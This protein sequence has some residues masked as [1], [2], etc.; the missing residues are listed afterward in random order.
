[1]TFVVTPDQ[2]KP[3]ST[4]SASRSA[5][6]DER[7][8]VVARRRRSRR[9]SST[10]TTRR[11][12][13][14]T[15]L[16]DMIRGKVQADLSGPIGITKQIAKAAEPRRG[17]TSCR[18]IIDAVGLPGPLQPAAAAGARR[19]AR[20][21]P[22]RR[23]GH[24]PEASTRASRRPCTRRVSCCCSACCW[25][26]ASR[27]SSGRASVRGATRRRGERGAGSAIHD[28]LVGA[29]ALVGTPYLA[30]PELR[31]EYARDIAPRTRGGAGEDPGRGLSP[32]AR[33]AP[34]AR[35]RSGRRDGRGGRGAARALRRRRS[36][37]S[38]VD[39]VAGARRRHGGSRRRRCRA[40]DGRFDLI[41][42][43]HLLGELFV[44][45]PLDERVDARARRVRAW[46]EAL[47]APGGTVDPGRAGAA[48]DLA[49]AAGRARP[50]A[51]AADL[52]RS[53]RPASGRA[54]ARRSPA[55]ATGATT[56]RRRRRRRAAR[57]LQLPGAAR[58]L[59]ADPGPAALP[60]RQRSAAREGPA[61]ALRLRPDR[62]AR[63]SSAST[64]TNRR[65][66]PRSAK[67]VRGDVARIAGE[68]EANDGM[69]V[70]ATTAVAKRSPRSYVGAGRRQ[71]GAGAWRS[72]RR[73]GR[74]L[75]R[76][77]CRRRRRY[78][79]SPVKSFTIVPSKDPNA[80]SPCAG[81]VRRS[82]RCPPSPSRCSSS[83]PS[84]GSSSP[85]PSGGASRPGIFFA[86]AY[87][88]VDW[89]AFG[90]LHRPMPTPP[91]HDW[92]RVLSVL[93]F[94]VRGRHRVGA[95]CCSTSCSARREIP[96]ILRDL[97][98]GVAY[99]ITAAIVLTRSEVDVT[100]ACS[101]RRCSRRPSSASRCRRR[102]ATSWP[103]LALQ[104]ERD[105][106]IGDW[107][108]VD[109]TRRRGPHP[110]GALARHHASSPR[111]AT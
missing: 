109:D 30:D 26:S 38:R 68:T 37:S 17:R 50:A 22:G 102:W 11:S 67:L 39:R 7:T 21:V 104:L 47:L 62:P 71:R 33:R 19:R 57:R 15:G 23:V 70:E 66:T 44:D 64:A 45:R 97:V 13:S 80:L 74:S 42:A 5:R 28:G 93:L 6:I 4:R 106:E 65:R 105:F 78:R 46:A 107:I 101:P 16:Y 108:N 1:M 3:A 54:P 24:A 40:V 85:P 35:A 83:S 89:S 72:A 94:C 75:A 9:R 60:R 49:R 92:L 82:G 77:R 111:T 2:S 84:C 18:M 29:R 31:R 27:T 91:Q 88:V 110:R 20:G 36:R 96:R 81:V 25:S 55:S 98:Q 41:V 79:R 99:L 90:V 76:R 10:R 86:G 53:S 12:T 59:A 43:A 58:P 52:R 14:S 32:P 63:R 51:G 95:C 100:Q 8:P 56:P 87:L 103:G 34:D 69:R 48:R 61:Q 73:A